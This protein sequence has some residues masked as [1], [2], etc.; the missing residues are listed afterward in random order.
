[1]NCPALLLEL[2]AT[3]TRASVQAGVLVVVI[4]LAQRGLRRWLSPGWQHALWLLVLVRLTVVYSPP[5]V[6][7]WENLT[8]RGLRRIAATTEA[9]SRRGPAGADR[10]PVAVASPVPAAVP[11]TTTTSAAGAAI[12][13]MPVPELTEA[14]VVPVRES[15][16]GMAKRGG[17]VV[18]AWL[19]VAGVLLARLLA[20][21]L[22]FAART[23]HSMRVR[24][25]RVLRLA[26]SCARQ[27]GLRRGVPLF[28]TDQV[29]TPCLFGVWS[30][31]VLL[32]TGLAAALSPDELRHV[33]LH[34]LAHLKRRD[35][36]VQAWFGVVTC[37]H[38]FNP[39]VW[40]AAECCRRDRELACDAHVLAAVGA[41]EAPQYGR[42]ILKL[43][44]DAPPASGSL[45]AAGILEN[46]A[47]LRRRIAMIGA[48]GFRRG[49]AALAIT[50]AL[51]LAA[52]SWTGR[53]TDRAWTGFRPLNL[54]TNLDYPP[55]RGRGGG[56]ATPDFAGMWEQ[57]PR[58][59]QEFLGVPFEVEGLI[60]LA[61]EMVGRNGWSFRPNAGEIPVNQRFVRLY[62]LHSTYYAAREN[63][64]V[65][66]IW[67]HYTDGR[68]EKL[69]VLFGR[70]VRNWHRQKHDYPVN[71]GDP[72]TRVV[73]TGQNPES[74]KYGKSHRLIVSS[75]RNPRPDAEVRSLELVSAQGLATHVV[76]GLTLG[77][78]D[79]PQAWRREPK[80]V[81]A[82]HPP[83]NRL[84][85]QAV[86]GDSG[87]PLAGFRLDLEGSEEQ[88]HIIFGRSVTDASGRAELRYPAGDFR[89]FDIWVSRDGF[90]P[91]IVHWE[92]RERGPLPAEY[93]YR[94]ERGRQ[95]GGRV[96]DAEG[97]PVVGAQITL[98]GPPLR[99]PDGQVEVL[100]LERATL[101]TDASGRWEF[102]GVP[103]AMTNL[104]GIHLMVRQPGFFASTLTA[105]RMEAGP[106]VRLRPLPA[107]PVIR[108]VVVDDSGKGVSADLSVGTSGAT[109][110]ETTRTLISEADGRFEVRDLAYASRYRLE[111]SALGCGSMTVDFSVMEATN[112]WRITL[113][114]VQPLTGKVVD[115]DGRPLGGAV[116]D[117]Y[118][119]PADWLPGRQIRVDV[120][121]TFQ[122]AQPPG[123][124]FSVRV[125]H[126]GYQTAGR[127]ITPGGNRE[128]LL[129]LVPEVRVS[130]VVSTSDHNAPLVHG[131]LLQQSAAEDGDFEV[132]AVVNEGRTSLR[133]PANGTEAVFRV[134]SPGFKSTDVRVRLTGSDKEVKVALAR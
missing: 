102:R 38:W 69:D 91:K 49:S 65:S 2:A 52:C 19:I 12:G 115:P 24:D 124:P 106:D 57:I 21:N 109:G 134:A 58:G 16:G 62:L 43:V 48:F 78:P 28:E 72:D 11:E 33:L 50:V 122:I 5:S 30:P 127:T 46:R 44:N 56:S 88:S 61:G 117:V 20:A 131:R 59:R 8:D 118:G 85:F 47:E 119:S 89:A 40:L 27:L 37:L 25:E 66:R 93:V 86:D 103:V 74:A 15:A 80:V 71:L 4:L 112:E 94:A 31:R 105:D 133:L 120:G 82:E 64:P 32:P 63:D 95:L 128:V 14:S 67:I 104:S 108:G 53:S 75:L 60:R 79:L 77:G 22:R 76:L 1:M 97:Q 129:K 35:L 51:V 42:T 92:T 126:P 123:G 10:V 110:Y 18:L 96:I 68:R 107:G 29:E 9:V 101:A 26:D 90:V 70:H 114:A 111:A 34:E 84:V 54:T 45:A 113:P 121:G 23:R 132:V 87:A 41:T 116:I 81:E 130:F 17:W 6:F 3:L 83:G 98:G 55:G 39:L 125:S 13:V 7:S 99:F 73:W 36:L 100:A